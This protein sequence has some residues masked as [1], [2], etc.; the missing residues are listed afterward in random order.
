MVELVTIANI[1]D[2]ITAN[3][4]KQSLEAEGIMA[5][6]ANDITVHITWHYTVAV[7]WIKLQV[8]EPEAELA[9]SIVADMRLTTQDSED[10]NDVVRLPWADRIVER[11]FRV[12][13]LGIVFV[14]LHL[15]CSWLLIR[16]LISRRRVTPNKYWKL[17]ITIIIN[18]SMMAILRAI[19]IFFFWG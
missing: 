7:K 16:L 9:M 13:V 18:V 17:A 5:F 11:M 6:L 1:E 2:A 8:P 15:Y 12:A 10:D 19:L 3:L 4:L 14:P